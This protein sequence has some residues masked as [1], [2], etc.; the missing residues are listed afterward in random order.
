MLNGD[1]S[2]CSSLLMRVVRAIPL[3]F[4]ISG[5]C[6]GE[7]SMV[8]LITSATALEYVI[9]S[10]IDRVPPNWAMSRRHADHIGTKIHNKLGIMPYEHK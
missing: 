4:A 7:A 1:D 5:T 2:G 6:I 8:L 3:F 10:I 9:L